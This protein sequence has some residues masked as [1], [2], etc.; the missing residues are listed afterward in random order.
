[1]LPHGI[2][3]TREDRVLVADRENDRI[4]IFSREG[5]YLDQWDHVQRPSDVCEDREGNVYVASLWWR[6]G[7]SSYAN[8]PIRFDLP[9]HVSVLDAKGN[10]LLR[11]ASADR[12]APG[13]FVAPHALCVDSRGDL[14]V[15]EV[16]YTFGVARGDIPPDCHAFQKLIR[17]GSLPAEARS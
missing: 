3:V 10:L 1:M 4:Q 6:V 2:C 7:Q 17:K 15:G 12:C 5:Q 13:N 14:Y 16:T 11:W 9:G 8:G